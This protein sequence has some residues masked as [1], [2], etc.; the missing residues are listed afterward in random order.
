MN[1]NSSLESRTEAG[2]Q[3][4]HQRLVV[5]DNVRVKSKYAVI[6]VFMILGNIYSEY[7]CFLH[8]C[9]VFEIHERVPNEGLRV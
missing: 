8:M 7:G 3:K 2:A 5:D 6:E 4:C 1:A 9:H